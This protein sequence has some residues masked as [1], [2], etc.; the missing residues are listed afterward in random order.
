MRMHVLVVDDDPS[1]REL[2]RFVLRKDGYVVL[3]A[4]NG[5]AASKLLEN[6]QVH[7]AVVDIMMPGK[8][9]FELCQEIRLH[10]DI[11]VIMLTARAEMEDK[12]KGFDAGTDDYIV[13]PFEPKE[14]L[15]R[16]KALLRRYRLV[17][18]EV[19]QLGSVVIDRRGYEIKIGEAVLT[20]PLREFELLSQLASHPGRIYTRE[21]LIQLIW[22]ADF[23]GDSRT[24][25]VHIKRLRE[26]FAD[27]QDDFTITT[28]RGLGYKLEVRE[29]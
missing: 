28:I 1:I 26:R 4:E 6:E 5:Q 12:E 11:P 25:D 7:L 15:F 14:L 8:D 13:K 27:R 23:Q 20:L 10:Y 9:G 21:Q 16:M 24:V 29:G 18:S 3:E 17:S 2:L 19:I 22:S